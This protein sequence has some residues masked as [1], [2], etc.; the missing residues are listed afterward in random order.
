MLD[1]LTSGSEDAVYLRKVADFVV[2]P[3]L[4]PDGVFVGNYRTDTTG[5]DLN[6]RWDAP[7]KEIEPSLCV[8]SLLFLI[9]PLNLSYFRRMKLGDQE[10]RERSG[11]MMEKRE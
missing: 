10:E 6:R 1:F 2:V 8:P 5:V 9:P 11:Q 3:M 7:N 4:N